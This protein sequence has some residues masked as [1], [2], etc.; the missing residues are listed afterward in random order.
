MAVRWLKKQFWARDFYDWKGWIIE[1]DKERR[2]KKTG[3]K[4]KKGVSHLTNVI[5][6][7]RL[8]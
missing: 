2:R 1:C 8:I 4:K 6:E 7:R 3:G 5:F